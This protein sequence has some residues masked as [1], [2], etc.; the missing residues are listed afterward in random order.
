MFWIVVLEETPESPLDCQPVCPKGKQSWVFIGRTDAEAETPIFWPPDAKSWLICKDPDVGKDWR[1]EE[2]WMTKNEMV[3]WYH[4]L[5]RHEFEKTLR[6]G[7]RQGGL[8][9][10][11]SWGRKESDLTE[12]LTWTEHSPQHLKIYLTL[13]TFLFFRTNFWEKVHFFKL[14]EC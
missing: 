8:A 2:K 1:Q 9:C 7:D 4:W 3:G 13:I 14:C 10:C 12:Q 11:G 5:N 6:V